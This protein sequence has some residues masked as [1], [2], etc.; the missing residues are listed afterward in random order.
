MNTC[1][2]VCLRSRMLPLSGQVVW[3]ALLVLALT[4]AADDIKAQSTDAIADEMLDIDGVSVP[5]SWSSGPNLP[6]PA[7]RAVGIYFPANGLF[8]VMGGRS[9][10]T[11]GSDFTRPFEYNPVTNTWATKVGTYPDNQVNN[12]ACG[13]LT[14]GGTAQIYCVGGSAAAATTATSRVFSYNPVTDTVTPLTGADNWPGNTGT[15]S[16]RRVRGGG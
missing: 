9:A 5:T 11:A 10:D 3:K 4:V 14:V 7:V 16:A 1:T 6:N 2:S 15:I 13:V 12:M 8:Y